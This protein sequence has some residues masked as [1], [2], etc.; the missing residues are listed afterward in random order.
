MEKLVKATFEYLSFIITT[1]GFGVILWI[2]PS[3]FKVSIVLFVIV[4]FPLSIFTLMLLRYI[5]ID[6]L[7]N[8]DSANKLPCLKLVSDDRYIFEPSQLF[9]SQSLVSIYHIDEIESC[10]GYGYIETVMSNTNNL[11]VIIYGFTGGYDA[12]KI[13]SN[14]KQIILKPSIT[15]SMMNQVQNII[16]ES[17][18]D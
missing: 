18:N 14:K 11:Q 1:I 7:K 5:F 8:K 17:V 13:K 16:Q 6:M 9:A 4:T 10:V 3:D 15:K 2:Y 12:E